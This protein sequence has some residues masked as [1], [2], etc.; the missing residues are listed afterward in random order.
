MECPCMHTGWLTRHTMRDWQHVMV[1]HQDH[2]EEIK[3]P[4]KEIEEDGAESL[5]DNDEKAAAAIAAED[6]GAKRPKRLRR[7]GFQEFLSRASEIRQRHRGSGRSGDNESP[8]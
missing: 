4:T 5:G 8:Q 6:A 3:E 1:H 2:Q 7:R